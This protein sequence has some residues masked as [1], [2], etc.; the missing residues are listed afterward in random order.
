MSEDPETEEVMNS[1]MLREKLRAGYATARIGNNTESK[2]TMEK[3]ENAANGSLHRLVRIALEK[4]AEAWRT[5][6]NDPYG[7]N[8]AVYVA[9]LEVKEAISDALANSEQS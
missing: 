4:R 1:V 6:T 3:P 2:T 9:L 8:T 5:N 7:I